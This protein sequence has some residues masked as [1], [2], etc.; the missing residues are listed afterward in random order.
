MTYRDDLHQA[1]R[2]IQ[3]LEAELVEERA[4]HAPPVV[5]NS[6]PPQPT[7]AP[8]ELAARPGLEV[9]EWWPILVILAGAITYLAWFG[10]SL[11]EVTSD[12]DLIA[13]G[14]LSAIGGA[15]IYLFEVILRARLH[16]RSA[17][18]RLLIVA[19][20]IVAAPAIL[21]CIFGVGPFI[22]FGTL[23]VMVI[24]SIVALIKW[25]AKG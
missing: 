6:P 24:V 7:N 18:G 17:L 4:K 13:W 9:W 23:I 21:L 3:D 8:R 20:V 16:R 25:I 1:H 15:T 10:P 19:A 5:V 22:G 12:G 11:V 2:R 14:L